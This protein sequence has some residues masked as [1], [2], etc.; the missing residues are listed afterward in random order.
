MS[1]AIE[2]EHLTR[3]FGAFTA[4][5]DVSFT[6]G[7]GEIFGYLGA[8]GAGKS[9]TIRMLC[10]LLKPTDG[11]ARVAGHDVGH[12]PERVKER[13]GY[14]S[15]RFSLYLDLTVRANLEFFASAYGAH[16]RE[17]EHRIGEMLERMQLT[18]IQDEVTGS[19][20]GGMQQRVALASA[21]L[22]RPRIV[23]LDEPTAGVDPVQRRSFWALIRELAAGG[24]TVFVT[25]HYMDE[26]EYCAR[27]GIMVDGR[28][29]ALDTPEGLKRTH[30]PGRV[31]EVRGPK[32]APALDALRGEPGV[33]DVSRF[34]A[35]ATVRVDPERLPGEALGHW[36]RA[37]GVDPLEMEESAPT[38]DDVFLAL[39]AGAQRGED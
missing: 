1:T 7:T 35:G 13:I 5:N 27:I 24:T 37:R 22:H 18:A 17:L 20:P 8:N 30:A 19:L 28:L 33:L 21:V 3:R 23:F 14:M 12:E 25:T 9:T 16:G 15:Q 4:V 29:V 26:A 32:L 11:H 36:L 39:T 38:L 6:V 10:G 34:G 31:L 2:V